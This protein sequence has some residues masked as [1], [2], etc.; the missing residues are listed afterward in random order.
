MRSLRRVLPELDLE[1]EAIPV[2]M[3]NKIEVTK[4]DFFAA[5]REMQPSSLREVF[6]E[7]PNVQWDEIG[8]LDEAKQELKEA[9]EWPLKYAK[10]FEHMN[11]TTAQGRAALRAAGHGQDHAGQGGGHRD[12]GQLH[13][14]QGT[15]VPEQVGRRVREG[16]AGDVPQ[17]QAGRACII[18]LDE[19]DSIAPPG[20]RR[21][22]PM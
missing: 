17:G 12:R 20:G 4:D 16:R 13:Q 8:G 18:F 21:P 6:V 2:E 11:A 10:L 14:H 15:G 7:S 19:I 3:L 1:L 9:V 5:L 22:T